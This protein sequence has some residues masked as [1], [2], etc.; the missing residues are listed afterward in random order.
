MPIKP[1]TALVQKIFQYMKRYHSFDGY[2]VHGSEFQRK[3]EPDIDG[4]IY[5]EDEDGIGRWWHLKVEVKTPVGKPTELQLIRLREYHKRGY[6][7]GIVTSLADMQALVAVYKHW[8]HTYDC[9]IPITAAAA[10]LEY[11]DRYNL[12]TK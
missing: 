9:A 8:W 12:W 3:G 10:E 1:E 11:E 7:V 5:L 6:M 4:S 2:H